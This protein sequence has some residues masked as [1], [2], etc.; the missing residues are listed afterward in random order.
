[1]QVQVLEGPMS[2]PVANLTPAELVSDLGVLALRL[3]TLVATIQNARDGWPL[4]DLNAPDPAAF[5]IFGAGVPSA[6]SSAGRYE[7]AED[8]ALIIETPA[9]EVVHGGIQLG[10]VWVESLD[11]QTRQTSLNWFQSVADADGGIRYVLAHRDPGV[12]NWLD[13]SGHPKGSIFMRWQSPAQDAYPQKPNAALVPFEQ[14][15]DHLPEDHPTVTPEA[16]AA[17]LAQ[18]YQAVNK[19]RNPTAQFDTQAESGAGGCSASPGPH[20]LHALGLLALLLVLSCFRR[21]S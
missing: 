10:N 11:Y 15:R 1:V 12:P 4:N 8:E 13:I 19:R 18:R 21:R 14:I 9:P 16:R 6:V 5:G 20:G 17:A 7:V 3:S 2:G